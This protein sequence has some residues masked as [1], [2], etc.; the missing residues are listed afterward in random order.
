MGPGDSGYVSKINE[1]IKI[2][3]LEGRVVKIGY[4]PYV[5]VPIAYQVSDILCSRQFGRVTKVVT[6]VF[7]VVF[8][9]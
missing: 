8:L 7:L 4:T 3:V 5:Q 9:V 1:T 6:Q 2:N